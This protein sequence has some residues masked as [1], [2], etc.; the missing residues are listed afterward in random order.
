M[1]PSA[2]ANRN[3]IQKDLVPLET[4][5]SASRMSRVYEIHETGC[6]DDRRAST[7]DHPLPQAQSF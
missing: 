2:M 4:I 3:A 5:A 1:A 6:A 7:C